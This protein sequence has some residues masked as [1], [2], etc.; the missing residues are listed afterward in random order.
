MEAHCLDLVILTLGDEGSKWFT[1]KRCHSTCATR[2]LP[3][4]DTV[5][6]GDAYA[7]MAVAGRLSRISNAATMELAR[8]FSGLICGFK[9]ALPDKDDIY[10]Y[11]SRRLNP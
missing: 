10:L 5:G 1:K 11:F 7:A 4:I 6:A 8:E 2:D 9:G 3:I